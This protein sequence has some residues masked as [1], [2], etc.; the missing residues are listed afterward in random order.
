MRQV[1]WTS[2]RE[3]FTRR[4]ARVL[5]N[6]PFWER[7]GCTAP[8]TWK[9]QALSFPYVSCTNP[10]EKR[11]SNAQ[12]VASWRQTK[13][14]EERSTKFDLLAN[15]IVA[16]WERLRCKICI[17]ESKT[18]YLESDRITCKN[19]HANSREKIRKIYRMTF[20]HFRISFRDNPIWMFIKYTWR[21]LIAN[22]TGLNNR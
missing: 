11:G 18:R 21:W 16:T 3:K 13:I 8:V 2:S 1:T 14:S 9:I 4:V 10:Y 5:N 20:F 12:K 22:W 19:G 15:K 7:T 17:K 6:F